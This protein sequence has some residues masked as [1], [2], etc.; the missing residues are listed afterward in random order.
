MTQY[1]YELDAVRQL[2]RLRYD[3][4]A[5]ENARQRARLLVGEPTM[6]EK[7]K[8]ILADVI[9]Q[10]IDEYGLIDTLRSQYRIPYTKAEFIKQRRNYCRRFLSMLRTVEYKTLDE[11]TRH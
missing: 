4:P 6:R 8:E 1:D 5:F 2:L 3:Y 10:T 11:I 9:E 7:D